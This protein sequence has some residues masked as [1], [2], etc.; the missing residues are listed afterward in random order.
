[1]KSVPVFPDIQ[2]SI[3][4]EE[5]TPLD[6]QDTTLVALHKNKPSQMD[7][8]NY[9]GIL[10]LSNSPDPGMNHPKSLGLNC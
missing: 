4:E 3:C 9:R 10:L 5:E 2:I 7:C 8:G 6:L 1:M